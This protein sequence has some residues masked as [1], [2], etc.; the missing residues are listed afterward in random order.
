[1]EEDR[2][3][4]LREAM[5]ESGSRSDHPILCE[6]CF[7][8]DN[9][10]ITEA[11]YDYSCKTCERPFRRFRWRPCRDGRYKKTEIC[12]PCCVS[13]LVCQGCGVELSSLA[14]DQVRETTLH[15]ATNHDVGSNRNGEI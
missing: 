14:P 8:E 5:A 7:G 2:V 11:P 12:K 6:F 15:V 1:M 4:R 10:R 3:L 13:G 9:P